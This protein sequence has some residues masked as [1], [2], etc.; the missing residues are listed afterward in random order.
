MLGNSNDKLYKGR[1]PF[2]P[3]FYLLV[4]TVLTFNQ[5]FKSGILELGNWKLIQMEQSVPMNIGFAKF[6]FYFYL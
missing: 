5:V 1:R 6:L 2:P 3:P 4:I